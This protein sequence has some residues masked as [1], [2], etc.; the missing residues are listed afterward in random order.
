MLKYEEYLPAQKNELHWNRYVKFIESRGHRII[1]SGIKTEIHHIIARCYL[2]TKE[3]RNDPEN[4]IVLTLREHFIAHLILWKALGNKMSLAFFMFIHPRG[5][6]KSLTPR[7]YEHLRIEFN[8]NSRKD[9]LKG[10]KAVHNKVTDEYFYV[11]AILLDSYLELEEFEHKS[12]G[13]NKGYKYAYNSLTR[14]CV[15]LPENEWNELIKQEDWNPGAIGNF[16]NP[17]VGKKLIHDRLNDKFLFIEENEIENFIL[18][19]PDRYRLG[20]HESPNKGVPHSEEAKKKIKEKRALQTHLRTGIPQPEE[21]KARMSERLLKQ[22]ENSPNYIFGHW[23]IH[24]IKEDGFIERRQIIA[25]SE[26]PEGFKRG[27]GHY[28]RSAPTGNKPKRITIHRINDEGDVELRRI[29][30]DKE[31]PEGWIKGLPKKIVGYQYNVNRGEVIS[32]KFN[33]PKLPKGWFYSYEEA[34]ENK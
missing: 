20:G 2:K 4:L 6:K 28:E 19:N 18:K 7:E 14:E 32:E 27:L 5:M 10:K 29:S 22:F 31:V 25:G 21:M 9:N 3:E 26:I 23:W 1:P 8:E 15:S 17:N 16:H 11:D 33:Q 30:I 24:R 12:P 34:L 13:Q